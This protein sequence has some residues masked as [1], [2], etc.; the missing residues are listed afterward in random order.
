MRPTVRSRRLG[1]QLGGYRKAAEMTGGEVAQQLGLAQPTWS[2]IESGGRKISTKHLQRCVEM[3][4]IPNDA[5]ARLDE[6]RRRSDEPGWWQ[7]YGDILSEPVEMLIEL[8]A[9]ATWIRSY[10]GAV[11]PGLLQTRAYAE[12]IITAGSMH[13]RVGDIDRYLNL[14]MRR[15]KRIEEGLRVSAVVSEAAIHQQ[16]GGPTVLR[17]QLAHIVDVV[18]E[19]NVQ[20]QVV[21][22]TAD[23]HAALT[24][25]FVIIEWPGEYDPEAVY[26]D[27]QTSWT[28]HERSGLIRQY[29]HAFASVQTCALSPHESLELINRVIKEL[30]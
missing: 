30:S 10:D 4:A 1:V 27:G 25:Q 26:V 23:A 15:Q 22:Y 8:E 19:H 24:D 28:V 16:I 29:L 13:M 11:L 20:L 14:R 7:E 3:F 9:D 6:L 17:D 5:A 12:R 2:K 18:R 21:P